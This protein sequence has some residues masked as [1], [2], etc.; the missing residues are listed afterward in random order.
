MK[1]HEYW[2][3]KALSLT[4]T[5]VTLVNKNVWCTNGTYSSGMIFNWLP[6]LC[7]CLVLP[8]QTPHPISC[9]T[10]NQLTTNRH[11]SISLPTCVR[12]SILTSWASLMSSFMWKRPAEVQGRSNDP[13]FHKSCA[14][15]FLPFM[16]CYP[17]KSV[18][19]FFPKQLPSLQLQFVNVS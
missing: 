9:V 14:V 6:V 19:T 7:P 16:I 15:V 11:C 3:I 13:H 18:Q 1:V 2:K 5:L 17:F 8:K 12:S 10:R 4:C